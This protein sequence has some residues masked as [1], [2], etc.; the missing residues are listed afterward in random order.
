[1]NAIILFIDFIEKILV[2]TYSNKRML[3]LLDQC[4]SHMTDL[5][6]AKLRYHNIHPIYIPGKY[7]YF[8]QISTFPIDLIVYVPLKAEYTSSLQPLDVDVNRPVKEA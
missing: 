8:T 6:R 5:V 2:P 1:M 4:R 7:F 3:F